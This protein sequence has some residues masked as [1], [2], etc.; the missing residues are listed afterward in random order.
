MDLQ[1]ADK[2]AL[3]TGSNSGLGQATV[4]Y[5]AAGSASSTRPGSVCWSAQ[6]SAPPGGRQLSR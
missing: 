1:L 4:T 5:L 6:P 2:R 3:V